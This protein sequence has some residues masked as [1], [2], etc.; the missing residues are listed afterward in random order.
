M[1]FFFPCQTL[2]VYRWNAASYILGLDNGAAL[3]VH[4]K[5]QLKVP[6]SV[7]S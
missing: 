1:G 2:Q 6:Q 4:H 7:H 3:D 5:K